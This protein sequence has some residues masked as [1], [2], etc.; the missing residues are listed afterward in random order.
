MVPCVSPP[1]ITHSRYRY[2]KNNVKDYKKNK[3][4]LGHQSEISYLEILNMAD[5]QSNRKMIRSQGQN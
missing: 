3:S 2:S 1:P 4:A 5:S